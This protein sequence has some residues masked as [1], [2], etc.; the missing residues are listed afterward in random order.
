[1][2]ILSPTLYEILK[3]AQQQRLLDDVAKEL[4]TAPES[5][6]RYIEEGRSLGVLEIEKKKAEYLELTEE[7]MAR[8]AA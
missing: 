7:G 1:M 3:R 4:G 5:L 8:A 6:M 2:L